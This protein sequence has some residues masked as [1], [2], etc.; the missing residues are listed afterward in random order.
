M[1]IV[2]SVIYSLT[3]TIVYAIMEHAHGHK[4]MHGTTQHGIMDIRIYGANENST[5]VYTVYAHSSRGNVS[6]GAG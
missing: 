2:G 4:C 1:S 6:T 3:S 5:S